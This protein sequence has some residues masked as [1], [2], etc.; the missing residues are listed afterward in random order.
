MKHVD[1]KVN[2]CKQFAYSTVNKDEAWWMEK[3]I[4]R[5]R[6]S[7]YMVSIQVYIRFKH[8]NI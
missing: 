1:S 4:F 3:Y 7:D 5:E 6:S 8:T 2:K